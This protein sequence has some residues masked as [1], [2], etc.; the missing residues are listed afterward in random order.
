MFKL[1]VGLIVV[2]HSDIISISALHSLEI[3]CL[4]LVLHRCP[5]QTHIVVME[6]V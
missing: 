2:L 1:F 4:H 5:E 6:L 3:S